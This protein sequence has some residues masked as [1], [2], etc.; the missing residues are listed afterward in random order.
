MIFNLKSRTCINGDLNATEKSS[1][2]CGSV[3]GRLKYTLKWILKGKM[4]G[5]RL[6][7]TQNTEV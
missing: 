5:N 2:P 1:V 7:L 3:I 6:Q 4:R